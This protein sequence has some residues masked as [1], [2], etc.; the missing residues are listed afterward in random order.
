MQKFKNLGT[1]LLLLH[2]YKNSRSNPALHKQLSSFSN[3]QILLTVFSS[4]L[5]QITSAM[6]FDFGN[7]TLAK[8]KK[9]ITATCINVLVVNVKL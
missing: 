2:L 8:N 4:Y 7:Y 1:T 9:T 6:D 3:F 5:A